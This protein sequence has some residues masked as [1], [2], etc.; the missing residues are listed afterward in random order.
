[1]GD[2]A[3]PERLWCSYPDCPCDREHNGECQYKKQN[4]VK[5]CTIIKAGE[6]LLRI[7]GPFRTPLRR[8]KA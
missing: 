4:P 3:V 1:M 8:K 5:G 7:C 6:G 2:E